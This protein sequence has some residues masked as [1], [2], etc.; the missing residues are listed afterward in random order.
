ML[1]PLTGATSAV[2][3]IGVSRATIYGLISTGQLKTV[4]VGRRR[5]TT[6]EFIDEFIANLPVDGPDAA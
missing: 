3:K 2:S 1:I 4:K 6:D 5:F